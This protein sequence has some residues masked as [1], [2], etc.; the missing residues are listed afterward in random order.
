M[1]SYAPTGKNENAVQFTVVD[2]KNDLVKLRELVYN[3]IKK[4]HAENRIPK[5]KLFLND[6]QDL[7][8]TK[9]IDVIFRD[10]PHLLITSAPKDGTTHQMDCCIAMTFFDLLC[11]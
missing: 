1:A 6:F 11:K 3:Y 8:C 5:S 7:W 9:Q 10:A 4:A 2:N